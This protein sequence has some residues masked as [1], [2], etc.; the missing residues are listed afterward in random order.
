MT[1]MR[2]VE[3]LLRRQVRSMTEDATL[4][5]VWAGHARQAMWRCGDGWIVAYTTSRIEQGPYDGKFAVMLYK[6]VGKGA[7]TGQADEAVRT[8]MRA[9]S[10]RKAARA[11]A[12]ALYHQ[13]SRKGV[14]S[15]SR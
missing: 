11:R 6:P 14:R 13:H 10:T 7:R 5:R 9:F 8:Y 3:A 12:V 1:T 2:D 15:E 4:H